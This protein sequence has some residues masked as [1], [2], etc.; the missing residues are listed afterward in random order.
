MTAI[1]KSLIANN[2]EGMDPLTKADHNTRQESKDKAADRRACR[3]DLILE[4]RE[5]TKQADALRQLP[6]ATESLASA[7]IQNIEALRRKFV[8]DLQLAS[9]NGAVPMLN[10]ADKTAQAWLHGDRWIDELPALAAE[11]SGETGAAQRIAK[12][13]Y[14]NSRLIGLRQELA[15]IGG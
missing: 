5:L 7:W 13:G 6:P 2:F 15:R 8:T 4:I 12:L 10:L 1:S 3:N 14:I 9:K 11:V